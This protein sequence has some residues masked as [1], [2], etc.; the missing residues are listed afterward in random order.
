VP[1]AVHPSHRALADAEL[2]LV[3]VADGRPFDRVILEERDLPT[4]ARTS[5]ESG[6][7]D[8]ATLATGE[9]LVGSDLFAQKVPPN[10]APEWDALTDTVGPPV[11]SSEAR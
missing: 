1:H 6:S 4:V 5:R 9:A 2:D 11:R 3:A 10:A 7:I 8:G